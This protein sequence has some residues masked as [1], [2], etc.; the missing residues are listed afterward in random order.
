MTLYNMPEVCKL[1]RQ[2]YH[3]VY[4]AVITQQ[5]TPMRAGRSRLFTVE[6]LEL[7]K[8]LFASKDGGQQKRD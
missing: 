1:L 2:P 4:H 8:R 7:L 3:R 6:D 5:V